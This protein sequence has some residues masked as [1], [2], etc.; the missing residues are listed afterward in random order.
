MTPAWRMSEEP[1]AV[2]LFSVSARERISKAN[3]FLW[4]CEASGPASFSKPNQFLF[5]AD[6]SLLADFTFQ[7]SVAITANN[8]V[9][10][11]Y[12]EGAE[13][14]LFALDYLKIRHNGLFYIKNGYAPLL[15]TLPPLPPVYLLAGSPMSQ[16]GS[17]PD[18]FA[19]DYQIIHRHI[20]T[21]RAQKPDAYIIVYIHDGDEYAPEPT[22]RQIQWAEQLAFAGADV[23]FFSHSHRYGKVVILKGTPRHTLVAWSLGNFLF[24][25]NGKWKTHSDV[26]LLSVL[27]DTATGDKYADWI[28]G[29]TNNWSFS[30]Y[31]IK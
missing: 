27:I 15:L 11:G 2:P 26:R 23:I 25:G 3:I 1:V 20:C 4:N 29:M 24:G 7:N 14:L 12:Q 16:R 30:L 17:G 8:H 19:P 5:H 22:P 31:E 13:N 21:L 18:I 28:Y 9:F 10:D 6:S